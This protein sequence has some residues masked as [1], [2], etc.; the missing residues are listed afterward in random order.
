MDS[1]LRVQH[2]MGEIMERFEPRPRIAAGQPS[3]AE[4]SVPAGNGGPAAAPASH[5]RG[6]RF[7]VMLDSMIDS[8]AR[9]QGISS[10]LVRAVVKAESGGNPAAVSPKGALGL[11]QLM[12]ET[13]KT[14]RVD[15]LNPAEN[16]EGGIRYLRSLAER[17]GDLDRT[18]AAY[19]AGPGA[20]DRWK[21]IPP[22]AETRQYVD[23]IKKSLLQPPGR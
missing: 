9:E 6:A 12:P 17:Y 7:S 4:A 3:A 21:G 11:M 22:Y 19:N 1:I 2:R 16:L 10:D 18:L 14:L 23:R 15:P 8:Q 13:A 5:S 20:V